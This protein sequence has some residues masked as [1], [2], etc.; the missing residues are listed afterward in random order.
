[1]IDQQTGEDMTFI[2]DKE[3]SYVEQNG[4]F[5]PVPAGEVALIQYTAL[6]VTKFDNPID[7][8]IMLGSYV[9]IPSIPMKQ[10]VNE[11]IEVVGCCLNDV[12]PYKVR[13][14]Q[15]WKP[16]YRNLLLKLTSGIVIRTSSKHAI[17]FARQ[18]LLPALGWF[19][20]PEPIKFQV[21]ASGDQLFLRPIR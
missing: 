6:D 11:T 19:D 21:K 4:R 1:M 2:D 3:P 17:S 5:L 16:G 14:T 15:E 13:D 10:Y 20:W 7:A 12:E 9:G 18:V 8:A